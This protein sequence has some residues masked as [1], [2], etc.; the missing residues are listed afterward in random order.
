MLCQGDLIAAKGQLD[1]LLDDQNL[2]VIQVDSTTSEMI[3]DYLIKLLQYFLLVSKNFKM[4]R[5]LTKY[6]RFVLDTNHIDSL[7]TASSQSGS[8]NNSGNMMGPPLSGG[9][10]SMA[11]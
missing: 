11:G 4:A 2:R 9:I 1:E 7:S 8:P 5:H 6:R 10:E 3:P